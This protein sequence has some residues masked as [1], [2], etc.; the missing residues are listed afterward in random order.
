MN[1]YTLGSFLQKI[2]P[3]VVQLLQ[4]ELERRK[5]IDASSVIKQAEPVFLQKSERRMIEMLVRVGVIPVDVLADYD[6]HLAAAQPKR[7][8]ELDIS[9]KVM[10]DLGLSPL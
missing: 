3:L 9:D 8:E 7:Q 5:P 6:R 1:E 2:E 10:G 4:A